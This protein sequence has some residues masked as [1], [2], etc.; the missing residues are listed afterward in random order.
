MEVV[1]STCL[2]LIYGIYLSDMYSEPFDHPVLSWPILS[3]AILSYPILS[4]PSMA[5]QAISHIPLLKTPFNLLALHPLY[6][7]SVLDN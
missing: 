6:L 1:V 2:K 3:Y 5:N 7:I 4:C